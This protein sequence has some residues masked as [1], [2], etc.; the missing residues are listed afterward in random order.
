MK[1]HRGF[2]PHLPFTVT[3]LSAILKALV[4]FVDGGGDLLVFQ[5]A[6]FAVWV[7]QPSHHASGQ[8]LLETGWRVSAGRVL[9][10]T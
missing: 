9:C 2:A 6:Q 1:N 10:V 8:V 7:P 3:H 4:G 5:L